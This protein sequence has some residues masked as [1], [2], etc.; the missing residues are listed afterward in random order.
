[1]ADHAKDVP[2]DEG[3][4][5]SGKF[6]KTER[7]VAETK[8]SIWD[9]VLQLN[10]AISMGVLHDLSSP[11]GALLA[12][13]TFASRE[14]EKGLALAKT[15]TGD[16]TFL[17]LLTQV[18][19]DLAAALRLTKRLTEDLRQ[20]KTEAMTTGAGTIFD[21]RPIISRAVVGV[22]GLLG[23]TAEVRYQ[24][25]NVEGAEREG[26][27]AV[28]GTAQRLTFAL[29]RTLLVV[30]RS[31]PPSQERWTMVVSTIGRVNDVCVD[32][33]PTQ[34]GLSSSAIVNK[35]ERS[36][37][38]RVGISEVHEFLAVEGG[39][40]GVVE[41]ADKAPIV[42]LSLPRPYPEEGRP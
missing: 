3:T 32:V 31:L 39:R 35:L 34:P 9:E 19:E 13:L 41:S 24:I 40:I 14:V 11:L 29:M 18:D 5:A 25:E 30:G 10:G 16:E 23:R 38:E 1:M 22:R 2:F 26:Q 8:D 21:A 42:R 7:H 15:G 36:W 6:Q 28:Q 27:W 37:S 33:E 4:R 17:P 12:N 20:F